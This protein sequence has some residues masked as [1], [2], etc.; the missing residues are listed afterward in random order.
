MKKT[1]E[2][3]MTK[4]EANVQWLKIIL[5]I[6]IGGSTLIAFGI[7]ISQLDKIIALLSR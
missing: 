2:K 1:I 4:D 3:K 6:I 7:I 5:A